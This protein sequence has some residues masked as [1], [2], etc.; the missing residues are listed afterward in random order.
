[1][2][3]AE[4]VAKNIF[5]FDGGCGCCTDK[6]SSETLKFIAQALTQYRNDGIEKAAEIV[7]ESPG[8]TYTTD[9]D[10]KELAKEI[11]KLKEGV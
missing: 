8:N 11:R 4:E 6:T 1:M 5:E 9:C 7:D 3:S 10:H 2:K